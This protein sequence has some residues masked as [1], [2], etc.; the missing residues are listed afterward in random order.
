LLGF[1]LLS[2]TP[3]PV[4]SAHEWRI[5]GLLGYGGA[6]VITNQQIDPKSAPT[7]ISRAEGPGIFTLLIDDAVSDSLV[8]G[9]E[10]SRGFR[11]GPFSSGASFT[12]VAWRWYFSPVPS[13]ARPAEGESTVLIRRYAFYLGAATGV[14]LADI[15]RENDL[16]AQTQGSGA[17]IGFR[18]GADCML[19]PGV[20]VRYEILSS[21]TF[22][23][24]GADAQ[25]L[26][27]FALQ[28][29]LFFLL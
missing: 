3:G 15:Y 27:E 12:G 1:L 23:A 2:A 17:Y 10:H 7:S 20:G 21:T 11:L 26:S 24:S 19:R 22:Y 8:F 14:A 6:G 4:A 9:F 13:I 28:G 18:F 25:T 29:G 5:G 16:V